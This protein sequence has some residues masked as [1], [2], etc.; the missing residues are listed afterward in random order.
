MGDDGGRPVRR[1]APRPGTR[2]TRSARWIAASTG[3]RA[4]RRRSASCTAATSSPGPASATP[5]PSTT[6][7]GSTVC[8][9]RATAPARC[10]ATSSS[11]AAASGSPR[12]TAASRVD[13][14]VE[15]AVGG[16]PPGGD[17]RS[18]RHGLEAAALAA[19]AQRTVGVDRQVADLAGGAVGATADVAV[20]QQPGG[21]AGADAQVGQVRPAARAPPRRRP[22]RGSRRCR[23]RRG[24]RSARRG[25]RPAARGCRRAPR[26]TAWRT[27]PAPRSTRPGTPSP[28]VA[29]PS[30]PMP[31]AS[32]RADRT[33]AVE[34]SSGSRPPTPVAR[35]TVATML[36]RPEPSAPPSASHPAPE[37]SPSPAPRLQG[38][39][40]ADG[41][42]ERGDVDRDRQRL[43]AADVEA[44]DERRGSAIGARPQGLA[45][46]R[47]EQVQPG[48]VDGQLEHLAGDRPAAGAEAGDAAALPARPPAATRRNRRR[49]P[50]EVR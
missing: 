39:A 32:A 5:P 50:R 40:V 20:E 15:R 37:P 42:V 31:A 21:Q 46:R 33:S 44:G 19:L 4:A 41:D 2:A 25:A 6:T 14:A 45:G 1:R 38:H 27:V 23:P 9:S 48:G 17:R 10:P 26:F 22:R 28:T 11:T 49:S 35:R 18:R 7:S 13:A 16:R 3:D 30:T 47:V 36:G 24:R 29:N 43:G 34:A 12:S 8:A